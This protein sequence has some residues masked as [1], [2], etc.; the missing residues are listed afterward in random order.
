MVSTVGSVHYTE[1]SVNWNSCMYYRKVCCLPPPPPPPPPSISLPFWPLTSWKMELTASGVKGQLG[2][3][4]CDLCPRVTA[5][6]LVAIRLRAVRS[7][8][9]LRISA[10]R[11]WGVLQMKKRNTHSTC[12]HH[13]ERITIQDTNVRIYVCCQGVHMHVRTYVARAL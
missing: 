9:T 10:S 4:R 8:F 3:K 1:A 11:E 2:R 7:G 5:G 12:T 6:R 13:M